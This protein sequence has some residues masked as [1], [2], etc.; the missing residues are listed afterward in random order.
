VSQQPRNATARALE[1]S[2]LLVLSF[3][4]LSEL[5]EK[6]QKVAD[7]F[8]TLMVDR[9]RPRRNPEVSEYPRTTP[10][11]QTL[12]I[13]K[14]PASASYFKLSQE[15]WF[16]WQQMTGKQTLLE[17][18]MAL[19]NQYQVFAPNM[20]AALISKLAASG[21]VSN[22]SLSKLREEKQS[23][24]E[25]WGSRL[26]RILD[27]RILFKKADIWL[28]WF[29]NKGGKFLFTRLGQL[30]L[31]TLSLSGVLVFFG[32][33]NHVVHLLKTLHASW[34]ILVLML[35]L[36]MLTAVLHELGHALGTKAY[37][38]QVHCMGLGWNW[39]RPI[40]FTD[41][42]DMWLDTREHRIAVNLAGLYANIL[43]A[44][45]CSL[46]V[47][48][49]PSLYLQAFLWLFALMTY[50][51]GFAMLNPAMDMDGYFIMMD[52]FERPRLRQDATAWLIKTFPSV[53]KR[54][55]RFL[56]YVPEVGYWLACLVFLVLTAIITLYVQGFVLKLLG[57]RPPNVFMAL[58]IPALTVALS[59]VA[60][61]SDIRKQD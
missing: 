50:I 36:M 16:I 11:G 9:S 39:T 3:E 21:F 51:K 42:T 56:K 5:W 43:V 45:L 22:V 20:V 37:G 54:P 35:P 53:L 57:M 61:I 1:D 10:E 38:R 15:G 59:S 8:M 25:R 52:Y 23:T 60:L 28:T 58:L 7:M 32:T 4:Y 26:Q 44:G 47:L 40:A 29:Y 46:L 6:E 12:V 27:F 31:A 13:L 17:I 34:L 48:V 41:T 2:Q 24:L 30:F 18:T 14:N 19:S 55:S 33:E 49:V